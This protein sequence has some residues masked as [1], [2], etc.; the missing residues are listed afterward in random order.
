MYIIR[1]DMH[2][3]PKQRRYLRSLAH[4][5]KPVAMIG[6]AGLTPAVIN[7]ID[8]SLMRHELIKI[9]INRPLKSTRK[10][11]IAEICARMGCQWVQE[12]GRV[13]IVYRAKKDPDITFP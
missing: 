6:T 12:I 2:I 9:K 7:E 11:I 13:A 4:H 8:L 10:E 1:L 5:R 3:T